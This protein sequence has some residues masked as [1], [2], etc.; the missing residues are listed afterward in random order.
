M[1]KAQ[2]KLFGT[3]GIR[4]LANAGPL[5]AGQVLKLGEATAALLARHLHR[6]GRVGLGWDTRISSGM[7]AASLTAGLSSG[8]ADVV[9]FGVIPTPAVSH[10]TRHFG[11]DTGIVI[12]ASHNPA[13]DNGIKYFSA[14]GGKFP[15]AWELGLEK[16]LERA[17]PGGV[18]TGVHVG[19]VETV[20]AQAVAAYTA[21][22]VRHFKPARIAGLR[23]VADLANGATCRTVPLV[24]SGLGVK[25]RYLSD[26]PDGLNI[27]DRCGSLHPEKAAAAVRKHQADVG[28]AFDGDGD[29]VML[30][31][32]RGNVINGDRILGLLA[33]HYARRGK[34]AGKC[35]V[36]TVMSNLGLEVYLKSRGIRLLR[37]A[38]GDKYVARMMRQHKAI[39]GGEQSGHIL[40]PALSPTGDG[41]VTALEVLRVV[42]AE[43]REL[44]EL[45]GT[46]QDFPQVLINVSVSKRPDLLSLPKVKQEVAAAQRELKDRGRVNLRYSGTEPLA[47]IMVEA[48]NRD[49]ALSWG[50]RIA[51]AVD[52]TLGDGKRR[53]LTWLTCA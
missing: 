21:D 13:L 40:L 9:S 35:V 16:I 20:A 14:E 17:A 36:A 24:F 10:L 33:T 31:D 3:D 37:A 51:D 5:S 30:T 7:L 52:D 27:N 39:L 6:R 26:Q 19:R 22:W 8:G 49:A 34:L 50:E 1:K 48:E 53:T 41:L 2:P 32:E 46:W 12:S 38:V 47:R 15:E 11:L 44:S 43:D 29:R 25:A 28:L 4:G 45:A 18:K 42:G 23:L